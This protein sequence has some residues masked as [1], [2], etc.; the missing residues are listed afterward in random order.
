MP[1]CPNCNHHFHVEPPREGSSR[2]FASLLGLADSVLTFVRDRGPDSGTVIV[3]KD[4]P[5]ARVIGFATAD[6]AHAWMITLTAMQFSRGEPSERNVRYMTYIPHVNGRNQLAAMWTEAR[7][8]TEPYA[9][10]AA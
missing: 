4:D 5:R 3:S 9:E 1:T 10:V 2:Q 6:G 8:P 7:E